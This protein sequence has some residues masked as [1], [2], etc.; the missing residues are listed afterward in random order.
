MSKNT[1]FVYNHR[2]PTKTATKRFNDYGIFTIRSI[3]AY[4]LQREDPPKSELAAEYMIG[5]YMLKKKFDK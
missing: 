1:I 5:L 4:I 3:L 2:L